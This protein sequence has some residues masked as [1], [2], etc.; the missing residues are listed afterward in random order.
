VGSASRQAASAAKTRRRG[1]ADPPGWRV[2]AILWNTATPA[3][4]AEVPTAC[5]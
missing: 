4:V 3:E 1:K 2:A 5:G